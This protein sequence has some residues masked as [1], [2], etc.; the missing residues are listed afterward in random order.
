MTRDRVGGEMQIL[1]EVASF[2]F[3]LA[4]TTNRD[5]IYPGGA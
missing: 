3:Y 4:G 2:D 5:A 1:T